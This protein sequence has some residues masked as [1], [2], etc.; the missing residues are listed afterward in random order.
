MEEGV[1]KAARVGIAVAGVIIAVGGRANVPVGAQTAGQPI[2]LSAWAV[3]MAN[4]AT[5]ANA[6]IDIRINKWSTDKERTD[7]ITTFIEKGQD[8]L[9]D[10]LRDLPDK[11]RISIPGRQ[12][13]DPTQTRLG[14]TLRYARQTVGEDGGMRIMIATDRYMTFAEQRNQ[15]RSAD[16]PFTFAEI[17]LKK[18]GTGEGKLAVAT[19]L[20]FDKKKNTIIFENYSTEPVRLTNVKVE[21]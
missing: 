8:K 7:L 2:R 6:V 4:V 21:K 20:Q 18:D 5:G 17:R 15:P 12:G 19:Q 1:M 9:L 14:W 11:G 16:Y 3:S 13:P 10:T